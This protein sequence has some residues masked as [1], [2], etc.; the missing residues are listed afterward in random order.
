MSNG[1]LQVAESLWKINVIDIE[2]TLKAVCGKVRS[3]KPNT[4]T[5]TSNPLQF[6]NF[7]YISGEDGAGVGRAWRPQV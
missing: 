5:R 4:A 2:N 3:V 7:C 1:G 6:S